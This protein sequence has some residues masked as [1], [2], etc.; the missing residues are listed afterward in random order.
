MILT[1]LAGACVVSA[2]IPFALTLIN[3]AMYKAPPKPGADTPL[4]S[5]LVPARNEEANIGAALDALLASSHARLELIVCDDHSEDNTRYIVEQRAHAY[6]GTHELRLIQSAPLPSGWSGKQHACWQLAQAASSEY[7]CFIDADVRVKPEAIARAY[8]HL[9]KA[10]AAL[11]SG[12][13]Y[14]I[15]GSSLEQLLIPLIHFILLG[16]LPFPAMRFSR[17]PAF[18]AGCGQFFL[19]RRDQYFQAGGHQAIR[20]SHHDGITLPRAFRRAGFATDLFD[21]HNLMT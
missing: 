8:R 21:A 18:A 19:A 7:V 2:A 14:Q 4:I 1:L 15:T 3:L 9:R 11:V 12:F 5:V 16:Y 10:D 20:S 17:S 13:P 6:S